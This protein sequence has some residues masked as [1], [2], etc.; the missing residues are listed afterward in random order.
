MIKVLLV[1]IVSTYK[2]V[3]IMA[4]IPVETNFIWPLS[5][6]IRKVSYPDG[7]PAGDA[8]GSW[9]DLVRICFGKCSQWDCI[10]EQ[11]ISKSNDVA[12]GVESQCEHEFYPSS[13]DASYKSLYGGS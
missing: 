12:L 7:M 10:P 13:C 6:A 5:I 9:S 8:Y 3:L 1:R 4:W 11:L 2:V